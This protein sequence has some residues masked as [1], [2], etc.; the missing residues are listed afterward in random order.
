MAVKTPLKIPPKMITG[1][2]A[3]RSAGY[4]YGKA[5]RTMSH[6]SFEVEGGDRKK[7]IVPKILTPEQ[8]A[9]ADAKAAPKGEMKK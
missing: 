8:K 3:A 9:K 2:Q 4:G 7:K 5:D 1:S 6:L